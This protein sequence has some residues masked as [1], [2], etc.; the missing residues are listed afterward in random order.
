MIVDGTSPVE[1]FGFLLQ[2]THPQSDKPASLHLGDASL[3]WRVCSLETFLAAVL[4]AREASDQR[5]MVSITR[6]IDTTIKRAD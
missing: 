5:L 3:L 6:F 4:V 1:G 2:G